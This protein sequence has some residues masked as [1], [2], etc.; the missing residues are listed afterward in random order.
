MLIK[1]IIII[2]KVILN[3]TFQYSNANL[4]EGII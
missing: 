2:I 3:T 4:I 1:L